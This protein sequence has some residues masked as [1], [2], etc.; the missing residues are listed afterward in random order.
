[1]V[2]ALALSACALVAGAPRV[3]DPGPGATSPPPP[4]DAIVL[5]D[6][7]NTEHWQRADG[8]ADCPWRIESGAMV[9]VPRA[10]S[11]ISRRS[12]RDIQLHIEFA[13]PAVVVGEGQ[14]R[15]NS[16]VYL[17]GRYEVQILDSFENETYPMGQ[18]GAIYNVHPPL[19]NA[20]RPP[21]EW[22]TY[23]I[24]FRAPRFDDSGNK[25]ANATI[26]VLHNGVLIHDRAEVP[27]PTGAAPSRESPDAGP[28]YLQ[29]HG[30]P[31]RFRNIWVRELD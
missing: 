1:M 3:V 28:I 31:V 4:S 18:C 26:T 17:M 21:G 2:R 22:Q 11:I 15:G 12:F 25:A 7:S 29:D 9:V 23:D 5:F 19:V 6:G 20:C 24:V 16:G 10:G 8:K 13:T 14:G 27:A 30:N